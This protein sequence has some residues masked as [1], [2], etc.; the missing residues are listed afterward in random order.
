MTLAGPPQA[1][2]SASVPLPASEPAAACQWSVQA[3]AVARPDI[4]RDLMDRAEAADRQWEFAP[5][6]TT[7]E[8]GRASSPYGLLES[9]NAE[10]LRRIVGNHGWP[11]FSLVGQPGSEAALRLALRVYEPHRVGFVRTLL[12]MITTAVERGEATWEQWAQLQDRVSVLNGHPQQFGTQYRHGASLLE[13]ELYPVA[14]PQDLTARRIA[15]GLSPSPRPHA[16]P[17]P[18]T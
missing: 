11:G 10:A 15:V 8:A 2:T 18:R 5:T 16:L 3:P 7:A 9:A 1:G 14:D 6:T 17:G 4:A 13:P 12:R